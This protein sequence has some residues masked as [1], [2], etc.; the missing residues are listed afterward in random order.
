MQANRI[1]ATFHEFQ[2]CHEFFWN[3]KSMANGREFLGFAS[4]G[5]WAPFFYVTCV[6]SPGNKE[7]KTMFVHI[8]GELVAG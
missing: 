5:F 4:Y 6:V 8:N 1:E 2:H 7:K 3:S